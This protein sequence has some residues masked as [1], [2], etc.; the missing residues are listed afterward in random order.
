MSDAE[1]V[2]IE[3]RRNFTE[4]EFWQM[5]IALDARKW[6]NLLPPQL[7]LEDL[8]TKRT[9]S[10]V[11]PPDAPIPDCLTCGACCTFLF[12]V[13]VT[14]TDD[15]PP[16]NI[17]NVTDESGETIID[18]YLQRDAETLFCTALE[19]TADG[20][21]PCGIYER[22]PQTCRKFEAGSDKC[23]ALRRIYGFEPFLT[24]DEMLAAQQILKMKESNAIS[25]DTIR[26]AKIVRQAET[27]NFEIVAEMQNGVKKTIHAFDPQRESW[28]QFQF[29]GATFADVRRMFESE[30]ATEID[31]VL[32]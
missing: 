27:E 7:P 17:W 28:R 21:T 13:G 12:V 5:I 8:P 29:S 1:F 23:H 2:Q 3:R 32:S 25:P 22:R 6:T 15:A 31:S 30:N 16:E 26:D 24:V 10:F 4:D 9:K 14:A 18:S 11:T 20:K 19:T